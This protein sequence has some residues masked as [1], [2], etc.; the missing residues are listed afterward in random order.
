MLKLVRSSKD[1]L[2]WDY[3]LIKV[4]KFTYTEFLDLNSLTMRMSLFFPVFEV[5]SFKWEIYFLLSG[6]K[7]GH[8]IL[9]AMEIS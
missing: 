9:L 2:I 1:D 4:T 3:K 6:E 8:S 5:V 7:E